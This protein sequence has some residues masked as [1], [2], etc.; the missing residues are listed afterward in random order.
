ML[1]VGFPPP[2]LPQFR[3]DPRFQLV[4]STEG[5]TILFHKTTEQAPFER[6]R[7][8][9]R[10]W[11]HAIGP[12]GPSLRGECS[13]IWHADR[14]QHFAPIILNDVRSTADSDLCPEAC[15]VAAGTRQRFLRWLYDQLKAATPG[16]MRGA[17]RDHRG[18][19]A[20]RKDRDPRSAI[21]GRAQWPE[22]VFYRKDFG[23]DQSSA[24]TEPMDIGI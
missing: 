5:E 6:C 1:S 12:S 17:A 7:V 11:C 10:R 23:P 13:V 8:P 20:R 2:K 9:A 3:A 24:M 14:P 15:Q 22:Q 19:I 21:L 16:L 4:G 18:V